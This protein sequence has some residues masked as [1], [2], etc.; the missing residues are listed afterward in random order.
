MKKLFCILAIALFLISCSRTEEWWD[1]ERTAGR[2]V[3]IVNDS[4]A[5]QTSHR[6]FHSQ[7]GGAMFGMISADASESYSIKGNGGLHLVNYRSR[8]PVV[9]GDTVNWETIIMG[10]VTDSMV[11]GGDLENGIVLW[12]IG[13]KPRKIKPK[14]S[15]S[16]VGKLHRY[17]ASPASRFQIRPWMDEKLLVLGMGIMPAN[18]IGG[19]T[20]QYGVLDTLTGII[21]LKRF[22]AEEAWLASCLDFHFYKNNIICVQKNQLNNHQIDIW[23]DGEKKDSAITQMQGIYTELLGKYV[24]IQESMFLDFIL[25]IEDLK[26][27]KNYS[28]IWIHADPVDRFF[29][30]SLGNEIHYTSNDFSHLD[31]KP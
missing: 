4:L 10:Q 24:K 15:G 18:T 8:Q 20:C 13:E 9:W 17:S 16:C 11:Y 14:W 19:D 5:L 31:T 21:L 12:K 1:S 30:D 22:N 29:V 7:T 27:D 6:T 25:N 28:T 2:I 26:F 3:G 23:A